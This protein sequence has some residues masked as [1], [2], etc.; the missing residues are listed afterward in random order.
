MYL[1][2]LTA[3]T[4]LFDACLRG[5]VAC[6]LK[7]GLSP[8]SRAYALTQR[9]NYTSTPLSLSLSPLSLLSLSLSL[10]LYLSPSLWQIYY[11]ALHDRF[12]QARDML[13]MSHLQDNI[14][15]YPIPVQ[16]LYN[17]VMAQM[18]LR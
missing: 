12:Y 6:L 5:G 11:H 18:G 15:H 2:T 3:S 10:S 4:C 9:P 8:N 1:P 13:L 14:Q 7:D 17:R 16:I